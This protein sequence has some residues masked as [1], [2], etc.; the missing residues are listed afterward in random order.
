[1]HQLSISTHFLY[2]CFTLVLFVCLFLSIYVPL[3]S[4]VYFLSLLSA[5]CS[6]QFLIS[7]PDVSIH[8]YWLSSVSLGPQLFS[9][10]LSGWSLA[11]SP[12]LI[13]VICTCIPQRLHRLDE[14][15]GCAC[16]PDSAC[17]HSYKGCVFFSLSVSAV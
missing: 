1:M 9:L 11:W 8:F 16:I 7:F 3:L 6:V 4:S 14:P 2:F 10:P 5:L 17:L 13:S 12:Y 15:E